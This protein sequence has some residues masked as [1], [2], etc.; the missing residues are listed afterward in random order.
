MWYRIAVSEVTFSCANLCYMLAIEH[1]WTFTYQCIITGSPLPTQ[2]LMFNSGLSTYC[3]TS[4]Q[5]LF[6]NQYSHCM[7]RKMLLKLAHYCIMLSK[8]HH[9]DVCD[10]NTSSEF[11]QNVKLNDFVYKQYWCSF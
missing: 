5:T 2:M 4:Y 9:L 7:S 6:T 10:Y 1:L 11:A 8:V 3:S